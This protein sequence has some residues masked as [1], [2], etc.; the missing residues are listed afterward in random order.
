MKIGVDI[1]GTKII[2][3]TR[4]PGGELL[5]TD[6]LATP[7]DSADGLTAITRLVEAI[8]GTE[9]VESIAVV[10]PGALDFEN[11]IMLHAPNIPWRNFDIKHR[12]ESHFKKAHVSLEHDASAAALA[13]VLEGNGRGFKRVL[14]ITI[15]TGIGTGLV[16]DGKIEH[17]AHNIEGGH[18]VI[19]RDGPLC[20]CGGRGHFEAL[21]SGRAIKRRFGMEAYEI[22]EPK[23]W[24]EITRDMAAGI[25]S[26][27]DMIS[28]DLVILGGGVSTHYDR[29][30]LLLQKNLLTQHPL[31]K[32]PPILPAKN[33]ET[34]TVIGAIILAE[35]L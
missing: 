1:G 14:Y 13:E 6:K 15:S 35:K 2:A 27:V 21:V 25:V 3:A 8:A 18:I 30:G 26:L 5:V 23:I 4:R 12:L 10:A 9:K 24:D 17:G 22:F 16:V 32:L 20:S 29:F 33:L 19:D 11:G 7:A 31:Y 28:P 34:A